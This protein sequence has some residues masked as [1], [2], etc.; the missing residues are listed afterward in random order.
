MNLGFRDVRTLVELLGNAYAAGADLGSQDI[1]RTYQRLTRP[2]N[3]AML[4]GCD[5]ME[6]VFSNNLPIIR[7]ARHFGLNTLKRFPALRR[8]FVHRAMGL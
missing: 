4:A 8:N 5:I 1:L 7:H 6:R 3:L 2:G